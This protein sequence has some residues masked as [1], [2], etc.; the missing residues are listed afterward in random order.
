MRR[1]D[2][3]ASD[4]C[5]ERVKITIA[6]RSSKVKYRWWEGVEVGVVVGVATCEGGGDGEVGE[7]GAHEPSTLL[8]SSAAG[9]REIM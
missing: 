2:R 6:P 5:G 4:T 8:C 3:V 9:E 7:G 1:R